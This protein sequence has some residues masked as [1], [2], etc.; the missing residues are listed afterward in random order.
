MSR[1]RLLSKAIDRHRIAE[2]CR[3]RD[4]GNFSW[5]LAAWQ[6]NFMRLHSCCEHHTDNLSSFRQEPGSQNDHRKRIARVDK[7][8]HSDHGGTDA[9]DDV[10]ERHCQIPFFRV[11]INIQAR[12]HLQ[13]TP[14]SVTTPLA[15][16]F[17]PASYEKAPP[18][19]GR[20]RS[21]VFSRGGSRN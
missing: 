15:V 5:T 16:R 10:W 12:W 8:A 4:G 1:A 3:Q 11:I 13:V 21:A 17:L 18:W 14:R 20:G 6:W 7:Q 19:R 2:T 9:L